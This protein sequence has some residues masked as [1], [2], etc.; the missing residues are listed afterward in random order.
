[1][2]VT[3]SSLA[4][5]RDHALAVGDDLDVEARVGG[6]AARLLGLI[7]NWSPRTCCP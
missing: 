5:Q 6:L 3:L 7:V 4:D 1:M 2:M